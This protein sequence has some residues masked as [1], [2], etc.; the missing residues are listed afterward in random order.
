MRGWCCRRC[1][2]MRARLAEC[3]APRRATCLASQP[4]LAIAPHPRLQAALL[5]L[6][7]RIIGGRRRFSA[8]LLQHQRWRLER[9]HARAHTLCGWWRVAAAGEACRC[10]TGLLC[11]TKKRQ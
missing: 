3:A 5:L 8:V 4:S 1:C 7:S 2:C 11:T 9:R 10:C 6:T